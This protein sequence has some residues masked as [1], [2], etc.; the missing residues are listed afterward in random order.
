MVERR[1]AFGTL[2]R[3]GGATAKAV[4]AASSALR[5]GPGL[6]LWRLA[7][8]VAAAPWSRSGG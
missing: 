1:K 3:R 4:S 8:V 6:P 2:L 7:A 5:V